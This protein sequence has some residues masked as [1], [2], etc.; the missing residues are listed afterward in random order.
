MGFESEG[1][2]TY[3]IEGEDA[4]PLEAQ[5]GRAHRE[6][7]RGRRIGG[8]REGGHG[9]GRGPVGNSDGGARR[10]PERP[11]G[12]GPGESDIT[13]HGQRRRDSDSDIL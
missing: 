4:E 3:P 12:P 10:D 5:R 2:V 13:T 9:T 7:R 8:G 11:R 6:R 1:A